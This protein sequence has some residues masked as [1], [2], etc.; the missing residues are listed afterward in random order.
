M[1]H[2]LCRGCSSLRIGETKC[3][4]IAAGVYS[5]YEIFRDQCC[6]CPT[7]IV[8]AICSPLNRNYPYKCDAFKRSRTKL[9]YLTNGDE[10]ER[11]TL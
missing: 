10:D 2:E 7:C 5:R 4:C 3:V 11:I 8:K 9:F 6:P 1:P